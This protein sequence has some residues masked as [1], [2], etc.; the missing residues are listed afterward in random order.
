M[1][2]VSSRH[3]ILLLLLHPFIRISIWFSVV[4]TVDTCLIHLTDYIKLE[5]DKGNFTGMVLLDLQKAFDTVDHT[6]LL[7]KLKWLGADDLTVQWF[8]S[9]RAKRTA[10]HLRVIRIVTRNSLKTGRARPLKTK[11][12]AICFDYRTC[13]Y[14][15]VQSS[16]ID[17]FKV[18]GCHDHNLNTDSK[19]RLFKFRKGIASRL[20]KFDPLF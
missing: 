19:W 7:N 3:I 10:G 11:P 6:I 13:V 9:Y 1:D 17:K 8:R 4:L 18:V 5:N 14:F 2:S 20:K 12:C 16:N 15:H